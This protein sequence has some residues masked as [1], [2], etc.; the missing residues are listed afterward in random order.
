LRRNLTWVLKPL[1][2]II[3]WEDRIEAEEGLSIALA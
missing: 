1:I 2:A 3:L